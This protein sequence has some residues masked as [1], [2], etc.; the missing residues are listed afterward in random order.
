M[1][2]AVTS[3]PAEQRVVVARMWAYRALAE[4]SACARFSRLA[5]RLAQVGAPDPVVTLAR[6][7][8]DEERRHQQLCGQLA[9]DYGY[10]GDR[11]ALFGEQV[12]VS[13]IGSPARPLPQ[14]V[15]HECVAFCCVTESI[16][17]A[18]LQRSL[19]LARD[20]GTRVAVREILQDEVSH[21]RIGWGY[22][23][24]VAAPAVGV[25][26]SPLLPRLLEATVPATLRSPATTEVH[27]PELVAHGVL[28]R[29]ELRDILEQSL[30][31]VVFPGLEHFG[32]DTHA[33]QAWYRTFAASLAQ[34]SEHP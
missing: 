10:D 12:R 27:S 34:A 4:K 13:E 19:G 21:A 7:A 11:E 3:I 6:L 30:A 16:N 14:R 24:S 28:P 9:L 18:L 26:L 5:G 29:T 8:V 32:V 25:W 1:S 33:G 15:L 20:P 17:V 2:G 22:L 23:A 31:G